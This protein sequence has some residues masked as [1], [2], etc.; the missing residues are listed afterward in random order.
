MNDAI[1]KQLNFPV[2]LYKLPLSYSRQQVVAENR[3]EL[4]DILDQVFTRQ[5]RVFVQ[6]AVQGDVYSAVVMPEFRGNSPYVFPESRLQHDKKIANHIPDNWSYYHQNRRRR[7]NDFD[8]FVRKVYTKADLR[9]LARIDVVKKPNN[10]LVLLDIEVH[11]RL[12]RHSLLAESAA[13]VGS[14][15]KDIYKKQVSRAQR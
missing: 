9:D 14:L 2:V 3:P 1:A 10:S 4:K 6:P 7:N 13:K 12:D 15:L 11:P 5:K 8:R